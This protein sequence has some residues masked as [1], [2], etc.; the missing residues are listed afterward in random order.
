MIL[1]AKEALYSPWVFHSK[2]GNMLLIFGWASEEEQTNIWMGE[3]CRQW[4]QHMHTPTSKK[5]LQYLYL[6]CPC[7]LPTP[8]NKSCSSPW[9]LLPYSITVQ[10]KCWWQQHALPKEGFL[11]SASQGFSWQQTC[12][13]NI[14]W[15]LFL[16]KENIRCLLHSNRFHL[17]C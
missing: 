7:L 17:S 11:H 14:L 15:V 2:Q 3:E 5:L 1:F 6:Y 12:R 9:Q 8:M 10:G 13:I 4:D 16:P